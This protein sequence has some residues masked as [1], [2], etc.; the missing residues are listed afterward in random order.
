MNKCG[1]MNMYKSAVSQKKSFT[2]GVVPIGYDMITI[3]GNPPTK[4]NS[5]LRDSSWKSV[6]SSYNGMVDVPVTEKD[7]KKYLVA[8]L[9]YPGNIWVTFAMYDLG[10]IS[11][12]ELEDQVLSEEQFRSDIMDERFRLVTVTQNT[13]GLT[14]KLRDP[15]SDTSALTG[16]DWLNPSY[17]QYYI[18]DEVEARINRRELI[19]AYFCTI[20]FYEIMTG[21][22][23]IGIYDRPHAMVSFG[24]ITITNAF[25]YGGFCFYGNANDESGF[26]AL[27]STDIACHELTHG[28][29]EELMGLEYMGES[30]ALDESFSDI[31]GAYCE[32]KI[33]SAY[34]VPDWDLGENMFQSRYSLR[35]MS[36]PQSRDQPDA[37][38][39]VGWVPPAKIYYDNGGVHINSGVTNFF[40]YL[41]VKGK[42]N[43]FNTVGNAISI[44]EVTNEESIPSQDKFVRVLLDVMEKESYPRLKMEQFAVS[45]MD[46]ASARFG[47]EDEFVTRCYKCLQA[48]NLFNRKAGYPY[49]LCAATETIAYDLTENMFVKLR[50]FATKAR[51]R[52]EMRKRYTRNKLRSRKFVWCYY[53]TPCEK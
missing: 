44:S 34:D 1:K 3:G 46:S 52:H 11:V 25:W 40:F 43:H 36:D 49:S 28:L 27:T 2:G 26:N 45:F 12:N 15:S 39:G 9:K 47:A 13:S 17:D 31:I 38:R 23:R 16:S 8:T 18:P 30:G 20:K 24:N 10:G 7:G 35:S 37:Y 53:K 21:L 6:M 5:Y 22:G 14:A 41:A 48:V 51:T 33:N 50:Q 29:V 32:F 42:L 19:N 4:Y